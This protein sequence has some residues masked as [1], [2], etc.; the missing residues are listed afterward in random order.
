MG[1]VGPQVCGS[2]LVELPVNLIGKEL[3][4]MKLEHQIEKGIFIRKKLYAIIDNM[5]I[6]TIKSSGVKSETLN[7]EKFKLLLD[8]KSVMCKALSFVVL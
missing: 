3:G 1:D 6:L 7:F 8:G 5:G 2:D 4:Q